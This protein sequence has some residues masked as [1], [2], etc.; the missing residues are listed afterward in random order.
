MEKTLL[1]W[2]AAHPSLTIS[3]CLLMGILLGSLQKCSQVFLF[4]AFFSSWIILIMVIHS[5]KDNFS[6]SLYAIICLIFWGYCIVLFQEVSRDNYLLQLAEQFILPIRE[7]IL[8]KIDLF[9]ITH[10]NN[11][12]AKALLIGQKNN[13][14]PS[15]LEAYTVLGIVHIIAISGMHIDLVANY[16]TK[17]TGWLPQHRFFQLL[18]LIFLTT[19][20][21]TYTLIADA[22]PSVVRAAIFF[23]LFKIG[24]YFNLHK[25][26]LNSIA[27]G[28]LII[29]LFNHQ[30]IKHIGWQLSYAAVLGIH[31]VHPRISAMIQLKNPIIRSLWNNFSITIATQLATLP[32]L[33]FYFHTLSTGIILGN[34]LMIPVCNLLLEALIVL[35]ILPVYWVRSLHWGQIIEFY[36]Q[37][38]AQLVDYILTISPQPLQ[39]TSI[40]IPYLLAYYAIFLYLCLWKKRYNQPLFRF[41]TK[42]A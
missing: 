42:M 27:G 25:Y 7:A 8:C 24:S 15:T 20:I 3:F 35:V 34:M 28:L 19:V 11:Q 31:L 5:V 37:K 9:I 16:L 12:L 38:I 29:L 23:C 21:I 36:M 26:I 13:I 1:H 6:K 18:E 40:S 14:D 41:S 4:Y 10:S 22:S 2:K 30:T 32:L 17:L 39:F 33:I